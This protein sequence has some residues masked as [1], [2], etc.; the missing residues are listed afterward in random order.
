[1]SRAYSRIVRSEE[2]F[3][4]RPT[5]RIAFRVQPAGSSHWAETFSCAA[6]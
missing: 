1:M 4:I 3:P 5:L 2:N 6:V